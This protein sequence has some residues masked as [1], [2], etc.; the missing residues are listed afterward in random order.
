MLFNQNLPQKEA[1]T[2]IVLKGTIANRFI[3]APELINNFYHDPKGKIQHNY[4]GLVYLFVAH[5][6]NLWCDAHD[7]GTVLG[8][9][10]TQKVFARVK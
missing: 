8:T 3:V 4:S 5:F 7:E 2:K 10:C 9:I 6:L 1:G